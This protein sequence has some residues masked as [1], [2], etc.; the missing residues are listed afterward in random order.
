[1]PAKYPNFEDETALNSKTLE[2]F[3]HHLLS[4]FIVHTRLSRNEADFLKAMLYRCSPYERAKARGLSEKQMQ[5]A[6]WKEWDGS[7]L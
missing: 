6:T 7:E 3:L 2:I 1:M 5:Q 4:E